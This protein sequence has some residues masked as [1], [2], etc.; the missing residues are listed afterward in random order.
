M[1]PAEFDFIA[2]DAPNNLPSR[3]EIIALCRAAGWDVPGLPFPQGHPEPFAWIK[4]GEL[5]TKGEALTQDKV[6]R[7][8]DADSGDSTFRVRVRAPRV[9]RAFRDDGVGYIVME[10]ISGTLCGE[11]DCELAAAAVQRLVQIRDTTMI[12]P[13]PV[14]GGPIKHDFFAEGDSNFTYNSVQALEN[15]VNG[16]LKA[17]GFP[18]SGVRFADEIRDGLLLCPCD[19]HSANFMKVGNGNNEIVALDFGATCFLPP[20]FFAASIAI[21]YGAFAHQVAQLVVKPPHEAAN[22]NLLHRAAGYLV[23]FGTNKLGR[24]STKARSSRTSDR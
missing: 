18:S 13:G 7:L 21:P 8:L 22:V 6:A 14:G 5:V 15:H 1:E 23:V 16:I 2:A 11:N 9:F 10:Y 12:A 19:L 24:G 3:Q 4:Y 17:V 20:S